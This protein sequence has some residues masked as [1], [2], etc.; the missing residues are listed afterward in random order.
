MAVRG[1]V[2]LGDVAASSMS[3][4]SLAREASWGGALRGGA[5]RG[6]HSEVALHEL[7]VTFWAQGSE[8]IWGYARPC[9]SGTAA[10]AVPLAALTG[11]PI[12]KPYWFT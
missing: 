5:G 2:Q 3:A 1:G 11:L 4:F 8:Y 12:Y 10:A 6:S 9:R 7:D